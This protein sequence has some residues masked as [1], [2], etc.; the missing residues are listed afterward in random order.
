MGLKTVPTLKGLWLHLSFAKT[1]AFSQ[2]YKVPFFLFFYFFSLIEAIN[3]K[4]EAF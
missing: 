1:R 3:Q 2:R 4:P